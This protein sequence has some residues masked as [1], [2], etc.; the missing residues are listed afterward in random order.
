MRRVL[1]DFV[2]NE[3]LRLRFDRQQI[4]TDVI[5][6]KFEYFHDKYEQEL[7]LLM[8]DLEKFE[9]KKEESIKDR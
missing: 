6:N 4:D 9:M 5:Y 1:P 7:D 2:E 8:K 3:N